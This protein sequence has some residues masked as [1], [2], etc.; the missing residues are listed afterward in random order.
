VSTPAVVALAEEAFDWARA[1]ARL[2][3]ARRALAEHGEPPPDEA[4]RVL[5]RRAQ[6]LARPEEEAETHEEA[7]DVVVFSVGGEQYG[8]EVARV[9][10][11]V[12]PAA[13]TRVPRT[14]AFVL[15]VIGHRGRILPVLDVRGL[16]EAGAGVVGGDCKL[17]VTVD[18]GGMTFGIAA[19]AVPGIARVEASELTPSPAA[20][21]GDTEAF[22]RGVAGGLVAVLDLDALA[23]HPQL[24]VRD[25]E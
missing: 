12:V 18:A 20:R 8:L 15:G 24:E 4:Q 2:E 5:E 3:R 7:A 10:E 11:V 1:Y 22:V 14:P 25:E 6:Q 21:P 13:L 17:V 9:L 16:L 19:E 23:R